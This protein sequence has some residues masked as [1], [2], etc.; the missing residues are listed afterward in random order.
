MKKLAHSLRMFLWM[1]FLTGIV[2]P[3]LITAIAQLT[4][5]SQADGEFVLS[6]EK[7]IGALLIGQKFESD[8]Y[9]WSRPSATDYNA[10]PSGGSNLGPTSVELKKIVQKRLE[11]ITKADPVAKNEVPSELLF[12]SGSGLDPHISV[13][14]ANFQVKRV[15]K[16]RGLDQQQVKKLIEKQKIA[17]SFGFLGEERVNVL[18][19]NYSLDQI[20]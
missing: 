17:P 8:K 20:K 7:K 13:S 1:V 16:A 4:M 5:K 14:A 18:L 15:A 11:K 19:L 6:K 12:A 3:L 10:L 2:Y 9:F